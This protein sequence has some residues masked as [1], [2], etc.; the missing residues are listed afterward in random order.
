M[1][2]DARDRDSDILGPI[3]GAGVLGGLG[4]LIGRSK[5]QAWEP[6]MNDYDRRSHQLEFTIVIKP[7]AFFRD[8][9]ESETIYREGVL[10]YIFGLPNA[11]IPMT[12]R[13]LEL[14]LKAKYKIAEGKNPPERLL[15]CINWSETYIGKKAELAHG[16]RILRNII[17]SDT[18]LEEPDALE[19][20]RHVTQII[21]LLYPFQKLVGS[22]DCVNCR[23]TIPINI[24]AS[25]LYLGNTL[26]LTCNKCRRL[27]SITIFF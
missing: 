4:Y 1:T 14:G 11:S 18:A 10:A 7:Y 19:A 13:C 23:A 5:A 15:D 27:N 24:P 8:V 16:F 12:V 22:R 2:S 17:H 25:K 3:I 9:P 20:I 26:S 21:N 6:F